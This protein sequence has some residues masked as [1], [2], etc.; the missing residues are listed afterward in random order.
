M[1]EEPE[2]KLYRDAKKGADFNKMGVFYNDICF[3]I[4]IE[5][6]RYENYQEIEDIGKYKLQSKL[7]F[8]ELRYLEEGQEEG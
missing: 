7:D 3:R 1:K 6:T 2:K 8:H 4:N 5:A